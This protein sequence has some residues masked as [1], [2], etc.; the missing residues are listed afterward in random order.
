MSTLRLRMLPRPNQASLYPNRYS[1]GDTEYGS[2]LS[3]SHLTFIDE[4]KAP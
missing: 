3:K 4:P 1:Y 2:I